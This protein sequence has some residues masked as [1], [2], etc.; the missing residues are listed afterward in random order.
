MSLNLYQRA[1]PYNTYCKIFQDDLNSEKEICFNMKR[2]VS[3]LRKVADD[4]KEEQER[5]LLL[6]EFCLLFS[7][8]LG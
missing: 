4:A 7:Q 2:E 1:K 3:T 6:L 8:S 5:Y